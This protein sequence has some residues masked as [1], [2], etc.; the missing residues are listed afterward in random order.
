MTS[1]VVPSVLRDPQKLQLLNGFGMRDY[2]CR[3]SATSMS[4]A[5]LNVV[6]VR[7]DEKNSFE[8]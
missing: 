6:G 8:F 4:R 3:A 7:D 5:S 1:M 2:G